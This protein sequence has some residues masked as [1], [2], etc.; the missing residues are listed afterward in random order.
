VRALAWRPGDEA[1]VVLTRLLGDDARSLRLRCA[2][3]LALASVG[4]RATCEA[5]AGAIDD[6]PHDELREPP[7]AAVRA[8]R[9]LAL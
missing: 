3:A 9:R 6:T 5:L 4:G 7:L 8:A 2:A 1:V